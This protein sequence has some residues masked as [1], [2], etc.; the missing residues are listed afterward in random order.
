M[1]SKA[2]L[3]RPKVPSVLVKQLVLPGDVYSDIYV[4]NITARKYL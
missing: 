4:I 2:P 1:L 3:P